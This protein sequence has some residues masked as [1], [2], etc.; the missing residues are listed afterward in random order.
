MSLAAVAPSILLPPAAL[1]SR[2]KKQ[3]AGVLTSDVLY[4]MS[5]AKIR[6]V[7]RQVTRGTPSAAARRP[8]SSHPPVVGCPLVATAPLPVI[9]PYSLRQP[10]R[11]HLRMVTI[12]PLISFFQCDGRGQAPNLSR[13]A[14]GLPT[15]Q[16]ELDHSPAY[17]RGL[18]RVVGHP[19]DCALG[20]LNVGLHQAPASE[21]ANEFSRIT[22]PRDIP[23]L[24]SLTRLDERHRID[25]EA[26]GRLVQK[27]EVWPESHRNCQLRPL[28]LSACG[29]GSNFHPALRWT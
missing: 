11:R 19:H 1:I 18:P 3:L 22:D 29:K 5:L 24:L 10:S 23:G 13:F 9:R 17:S 7:P 28:C 27:K 21:V 16:R 2:R 12:S 26:G 15:C 20:R 6:L 14:A 4:I 8:A 25:V